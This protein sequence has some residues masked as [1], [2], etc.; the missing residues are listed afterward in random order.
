MNE[1][2]TKE[3][4]LTKFYVEFDFTEEE[5]IIIRKKLAYEGNCDPDDISDD[6]IAT[7]LDDWF[8]AYFENILEEWEEDVDEIDLE[9]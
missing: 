6:D 4:G 7:Y 5:G 3:N 8:Q 1:K 9:I 2:I